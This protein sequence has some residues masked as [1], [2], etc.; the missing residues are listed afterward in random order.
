MRTHRL[1]LLVLAF[2]TTVCA[3][4][5][6]TL[7]AA[8]LVDMDIVMIRQ[9]H[10]DILICRPWLAGP[11]QGHWLWAIPDDA[12]LE[13]L[14]TISINALIFP[15]GT[16]INP[17]SPLNQSPLDCEQQDL[18]DREPAPCQIIGSYSSPEALL[19]GCEKAEIILTEEEQTTL[20]SLW[21]NHHKV[22]LLQWQEGEPDCYGQTWADDRRPLP[23][24]V[25]ERS[26]FWNEL[27]VHWP[28][29]MRGC[30][31]LFAMVSD[32]PLVPSPDEADAW[33]SS[34]IPLA[35]KPELK[36]VLESIA[37]GISGDSPL[38][39][40]ALRRCDDEA[41]LHPVPLDLMRD[42]TGSNAQVAA[43]WAGQ[44][45]SPQTAASL[46][47][48]LADTSV[49]GQE[50]AFTIWAWGKQNV[51]DKA[52]VLAPWL[53]SRDSLVRSEAVEALRRPD[54]LTFDF[55]NL[56]MPDLG[57]RYWQNSIN[58]S[59]W[60]I[61]QGAAPSNTTV[62]RQ[63]ADQ[64]HGWLEWTTQTRHT[65]KHRSRG[66]R[67]LREKELS[68]GQWAVLTLARL[69]DIQAIRCIEN[70]FR[71]S[72]GASLLET[73]FS[74]RAHHRIPGNAWNI[75]LILNPFE[76]SKFWP[77]LYQFNLASACLPEFRD[78]FLSRALDNGAMPGEAVSVLLS[79]ISKWS[80]Q[81]ELNAWTTL[82]ISR[83]LEPT[84]NT[85]ADLSRWRWRMTAAGDG[86][87]LVQRDHIKMIQQVMTDCEDPQL[88][89]E[90][91][92]ALAMGGSD[93]I[94]DEM[95]AL[96]LNCW[97]PIL[98]RVPPDE[99]HR[100]TEAKSFQMGFMTSYLPEHQVRIMK[101]YLSQATS[102][103][104]LCNRLITRQELSPLLIA[105]LNNC[106]ENPL[107]KPPYF[108]QGYCN[109][110]YSWWPV[111]K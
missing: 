109:I 83:I 99:V 100:Q 104:K 82:D 56:T 3:L 26:S 85:D 95:E 68:A 97:Q 10:H 62:L 34:L 73:S 60:H 40:A 53:H 75:H 72:A 88:R 65:A 79:R 70:S 49:T 46:R 78:Q 47:R 13:K 38:V 14:T 106:Q 36:Q 86:Y 24:F 18:T 21:Q 28:E 37:P 108:S 105:F 52:A 92:M 74:R 103:R 16:G 11:A 96:L 55:E 57:G 51:P 93:E 25:L 90:F 17:L 54:D 61:L 76:L 1:L 30:R 43:A 98:A 102:G 41:S 69:G 81:D 67:E 91:L 22:V 7:G 23:A 6:Q 107:R 2:T 20:E 110:V 59:G 8:T 35:M 44:H 71:L 48:A 12:E 39:I 89:T 19:A 66:H 101:W 15:L 84:E 9:P 32:V 50:P 63:I 94:E 4:S 31:G 111:G 64:N 58:L 27:P 77:T 45:P 87:V 29:S 42:L 80:S 5:R 33:D